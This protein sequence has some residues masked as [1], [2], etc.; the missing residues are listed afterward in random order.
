MRRY[1]RLY[2]NFVRFSFSRA[3]EFRFDFFFR[4]GMDALWYAVIYSFFKLLF[5][6]TNSVGGWNESQALLLAGGAFVSDALHM[7]VFSGN[8]W[9]LP[10]LVNRGDLDYYLVRPVSPLFILSTR[11]FAVNSLLNLVIA[12]VL[13][14]CILAAH[15]HAWSGIRLPIYVLFL[16]LGVFLNY[17][18]NLIFLTP[19]FWIHN[20]T[21]L[22]ELGSSMHD[23]ATRPDGIFTGTMRRL[24]T[25]ILP[26]ILI[27]SYP[28]RLLFADN[29]ATLMLH[30][31]AVTAALFAL[32][33]WFWRRGVR[34]YSSASS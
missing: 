27:V 28:T 7:T 18:I 20:A 22:R 19:V 2:A 30:M 1:V 33:V 21:G 9:W 15:P 34:A 11:D 4:V 13:L 29:P 8:T 32:A 5:L 23:Y 3:M 6:K 26:F 17:V 10:I 24:L 25:T 12:V 14:V 31:L 16:L